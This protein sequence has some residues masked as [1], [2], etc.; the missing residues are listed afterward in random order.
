M[1]FNKTSRIFSTMQKIYYQLYGHIYETD[2][3]E[4]Y[5]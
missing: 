1:K 3:N 5:S 4:D 2:T